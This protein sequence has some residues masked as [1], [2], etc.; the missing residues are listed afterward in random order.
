MRKLVVIISEKDARVVLLA[1]T[2]TSV[3]GAVRKAM[4]VLTAKV[5]T[6]SNT[7]RALE[8]LD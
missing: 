4:G 2:C 8:D 6:R 5:R 3:N 7:A 1:S